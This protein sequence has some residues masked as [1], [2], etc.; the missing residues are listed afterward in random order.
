M[1]KRDC[2]GLACPQPV[3]ITKELVDQYP[4]ELIEVTVDN[5]AAMENVSRFFQSQGWSVSVTSDK[6]GE[7]LVTGAPGTCKISH[8]QPGVEEGVDQ[9]ILVFIPTDIFGAGDQELGRALMKNFILTL[10]E[11]GRDLWRIVLVNGGVR[12]AV[13]GSPVL[14][15][16][17]NLADSGVDILV[18]GTCLEYF[19]LLEKKEVGHTT[20]ML[21][22]VTSMH[23]ASKVVRI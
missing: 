11:I 3:L 8:D 4:E 9:K 23:I 16:L 19:S 22:I 1:Q 21:D 12:L 2:R 7:F 6:D 10:G 18:C 5:K 14:D 15:A 13:K 20:N 17:K